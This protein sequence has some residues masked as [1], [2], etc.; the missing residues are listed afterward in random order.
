MTLCDSIQAL[1]QGFDVTYDIWLLYF[2]GAPRSRLLKIKEARTRDLDRYGDTV[3]TNVP[4]DV[5][6]SFSGQRIVKKVL[7]CNLHELLLWLKYPIFV[8][9]IGNFISLLCFG[10]DIRI[11]DH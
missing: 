7:V 5:D 4:L 6:C 8:L 2:K 9:G 3:V 11:F 1:G 10:F